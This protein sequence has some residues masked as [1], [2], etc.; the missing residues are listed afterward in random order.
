MLRFTSYSPEETDRF[1]FS[2]GELLR[3]GDFVALYGD[4]GAGK[5]R[6]AGGV[7][8]G[9]GADP[10]IP[11]TSPTYTLLNIHQGRLPLYHFDLYRLSGLD[12]AIDLGFTEY[13]AGDGVS[14]V[15]WPERLDGDLPPARIDI[16]LSYAGDESREICLSSPAAGM[17]DRF[18]GLM[19]G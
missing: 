19:N 10:A 17:L 9:L 18:T 2:F 7:A 16:A 6:F 14:L 1:A 15:E 11:V 13:F 4:L 5:T 8:R 3:G 12:E